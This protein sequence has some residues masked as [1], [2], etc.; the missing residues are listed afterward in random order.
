MTGDFRVTFM[1][2]ESAESEVATVLTVIPAYNGGQWIRECLET[3]CSAGAG[4]IVVVDNASSDDTRAIVDEVSGQRGSQITLIAN[5]RNVGFGAA[6]NQGLRIAAAR[7]I[8]F[9][10]VVN[11]DLKFDPKVFSELL[12]VTSSHPR[13]GLAGALALSYDGEHLDRSFR[14][15]LPADYW[16]D[17]VLGTAKAFYAMPFVPAAAVL[18]RVSAVIEVG[19]FDPIFFMY[20][21]D[22]ELCIRLAKAGYEIGVVPAARVLHYH[23]L[24]HADKKALKWLMHF[25]YTRVV[26]MVKRTGASYPKL[27]YRVARE[28]LG[29][30]WKLGLSRS[31]AI[32]RVSVMWPLFRSTASRKRCEI[33]SSKQTLESPGPG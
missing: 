13:L 6:A 26:L 2:D 22:N 28:W 24:V 27:L 4:P 17:L 9:V 5:E 23:G 20:G 19:G 30:L 18:I 11:Q 31:L 1:R 12:D 7:Q 16:D 10:F 32:V 8:P 29:M 25:E 3:L 15:F 14:Q 21:E 33:A